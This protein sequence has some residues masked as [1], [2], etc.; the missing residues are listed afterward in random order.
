MAEEEYFRKVM[1]AVL[2]FILIILCFFLIKPILLS[3]IFGVIMVFIFSPPYNF[4]NR[5]IKSKTLCASIISI[6]LAA[7]IILP[8]WFFTP[9]IID[10]SFKMFQAIQTLDFITPLKSVFP[11]LFTSESFTAEV[12]S[13]LHSFLSSTTNS[14]VNGF[15][16]LILDFPNLS[17]QFLVM[18]FTFFFVLRDKEELIVYIKSLLPFSKDVEEKIFKYSEGITWSVIYGQI[19]LGIGQGILTGIGFFVFGVPNAFFLMLLAILLGIL[20]VLGTFLVWIPV[21]IYMMIN[22]GTEAGLGIA[23]FG[24]VASLLDNFFRPIIIARRTQIHT[25][26]ILIGMIGGIFLFGVLGIILGPL[27]ISY[28]VILLEIYRNKRMPGIL[29]QPNPE[30]AK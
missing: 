1:T 24:I 19:I 17:L 9:V 5:F 10:Q 11:S 22:N 25:G 23:I 14:I 27:I 7:V 6:I 28:L 3:I 2:L 21:A 13:I 4:L 15:A 26:L 12:A 18:A 8:I 30:G 29:I 20:P 16:S